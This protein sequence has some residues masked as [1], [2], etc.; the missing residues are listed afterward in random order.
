MAGDSLVIVSK[1]KEYIKN[2]TIGDQKGF[3]V[4]MDFVEKLS[5]KVENIVK[6]A[7]ERAKANNRR[8]VQSKDL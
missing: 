7:C 5:K 3:N 6:E 2:I 1:T 4:S 8:T